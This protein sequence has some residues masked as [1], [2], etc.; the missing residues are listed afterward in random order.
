[1]KVAAALAV[2]DGHLGTKG[3][4]AEDWRLAG[5]LM[6][7]SDATRADV[8][9]DLCR[10]AAEANV[11]RAKAEGVREVIKSDT[12]EA[13][14]VQKASRAA[15]T[16]LMKRPGE[17]MTGAE[18]R[19]AVASRVRPYLDTA[20]EALVLAGSVEVEPIDHH[21]QLGRRYRGRP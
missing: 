9:A 7:V 20:L 19:R 16:A 21:S 8:Q 5:V 10:T 11:A 12:L 18:L 3:V 1:L 2:L 14:A 4:T 17:W 6:A 15:I 13:A